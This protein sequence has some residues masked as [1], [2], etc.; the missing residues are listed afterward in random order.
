MKLVKT[1][2]FKV[3]TKDKEY[4]LKEKS[5]ASRCDGEII[6]EEIIEKTYH[7]AVAEGKDTK[8]IKFEDASLGIKNRILKLQK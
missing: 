5:Y 1:V 3:I 7:N 4:F 2:Y 6:T 8:E